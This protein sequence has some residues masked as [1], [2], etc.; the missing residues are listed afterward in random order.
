MFLPSQYHYDDV[1]DQRLRCSQ[2]RTLLPEI[3]ALL[4]SI[5]QGKDGSERGDGDKEGRE[6]K[7]QYFAAAAAVAAVAAEAAAAGGE[8]V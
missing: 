1:D 5:S 4:G 7:E 8:K 2:L 3:E 6:G